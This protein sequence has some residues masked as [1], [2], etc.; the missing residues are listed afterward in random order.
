MKRRRNLRGKNWWGLAWNTGLLA[1]EA[2]HVIGL[3]VAKLM[4]G[5]PEATK[6]AASMVSEKMLA[7][8]EAAM[9]L[10]SGGSGLSVIHDYRRKVRSNRKRLTK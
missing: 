4:T 3:R 7:A 6:E 1:M 8:A 2:Q 9:K 10:A 5:G